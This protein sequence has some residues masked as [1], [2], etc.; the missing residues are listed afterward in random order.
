MR[1]ALIRTMVSPT[2]FRVEWYRVCGTY[3]GAQ[4]HRTPYMFPPT[5]QIVDGGVSGDLTM[6]ARRARPGHL[7]D[8]QPGRLPAQEGHRTGMRLVL[9][10]VSGCGSSPGPGGVRSASMP[11]AGTRSADRDRIL[12]GK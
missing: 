7:R 1:G 11:S 4:P 3:Q 9:V 12:R 5:Y 8:L 2:G 6:A 10:A